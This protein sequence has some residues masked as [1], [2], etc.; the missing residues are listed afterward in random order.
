MS[1]TNI[2]QIAET[3]VELSYKDKNKEQISKLLKDM[4]KI[5]K[6]ERKKYV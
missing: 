2:K 3:I 1:I 6:L 5:V 4:K